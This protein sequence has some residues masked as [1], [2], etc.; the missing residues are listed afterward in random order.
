VPP[1][2]R[3]ALR[4][5]LGLPPDAQVLFSL[6]RLIAKKGFADLLEA[7]ARL[8]AEPGGRPLRLVI[9]G[10]GPDRAALEE[11]TRRLGLGGR[12]HWAGWQDDPSPS[13]RWPTCSSARRATSRSAT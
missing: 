11:A 12:V 5:R 2:E 9:A 3:A 4:A 6:G 13:T 1:E 7:F 10:D 8:P